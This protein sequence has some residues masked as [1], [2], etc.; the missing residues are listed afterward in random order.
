MYGK[1]TSDLMQIFLL[2]LST[3]ALSTW[4]QVSVNYSQVTFNPNLSHCVLL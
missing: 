3:L 2:V 4:P 1:D